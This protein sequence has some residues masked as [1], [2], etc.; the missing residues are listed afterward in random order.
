M[1]GWLFG[2]KEKVQYEQCAP[3]AKVNHLSYVVSEPV[4]AIVG[5]FNEKGRWDL[6]IKPYSTESPILR[7]RIGW[8]VTDTLTGESY[9]V[10]SSYLYYLLSFN[11]IKLEPDRVLSESLPTWMT[12]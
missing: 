8:D 2:K 6:K 7:G 1:F 12:E 4:H 10:V 3:T 9:E 5:T 11:G